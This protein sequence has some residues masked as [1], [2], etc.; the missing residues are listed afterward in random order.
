MYEILNS[1]S[2]STKKEGR[3]ERRE[4]GKTWHAHGLEDSIVLKGRY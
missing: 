4:R 3:R 2:S 1:N